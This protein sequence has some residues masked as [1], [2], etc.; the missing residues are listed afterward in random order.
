MPLVHNLGLPYDP[1][2]TMFG[3]LAAGVEAVDCVCAG[4]V[5]IEWVLHRFSLHVPSDIVLVD[6]IARSSYELLAVGVDTDA[7]FAAVLL[8]VGGGIVHSV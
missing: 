4:I 1:S 2:V 7:S 3:Q 8:F 5:D 6:H